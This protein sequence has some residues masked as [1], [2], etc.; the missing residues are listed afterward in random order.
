MKNLTRK[1]IIT[2][3]SIQHYPPF[4]NHPQRSIQFHQKKK[5]TLT[6]GFKKQNK[7]DS[8]LCII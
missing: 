8:I 4:W 3:P 7:N 5:M 6:L 1:L 2:R